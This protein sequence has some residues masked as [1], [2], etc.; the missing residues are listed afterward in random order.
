MHEHIKVSAYAKCPSTDER[1]KKMWYIIPMKYYSA[2]KQS[3]IFGHLDGSVGE[4]SDFNLGHDLT[5]HEFKPCLALSAVGTE[6]ALD[7]LS[8]SICPFSPSSLKSE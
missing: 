3:E 7:P 6:L 4:A 5:V 1:I 8:P 2:I